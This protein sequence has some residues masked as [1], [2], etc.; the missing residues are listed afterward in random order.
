MKRTFNFE[1]GHEKINWRPVM[2]NLGIVS[3]IFELISYPLVI[4]FYFMGN[5]E[6]GF[7]GLCYMYLC[8]IIY[9]FQ[10]KICY[11]LKEGFYKKSIKKIKIWFWVNCLL[12][13]LLSLE[14]IIF[15]KVFNPIGVF[16]LSLYFLIYFYWNNPKQKKYFDSLSIN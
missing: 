16:E 2:I 5:L 15:F 7:L 10:I 6:Y 13:I 8:P 14:S 1:N 4:I 3:S 9:I 12:T 11:Q